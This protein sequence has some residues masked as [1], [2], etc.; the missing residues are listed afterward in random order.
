M[1]PSISRVPQLITY[2]EVEG[3]YKHQLAVV[4]RLKKHLKNRLDNMKVSNSSGETEATSVEELDFEEAADL[5]EK[6]ENRTA[7]IN[8]LQSAAARSNDQVCVSLS[9]KLVGSICS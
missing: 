5:I 8:D 4:N 7:E 2:A 1:Y 9:S 6:I 3:H